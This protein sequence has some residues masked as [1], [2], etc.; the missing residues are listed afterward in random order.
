[1]KNK[2]STFDLIHTDDGCTSFHSKIYNENGHSSAGARTETVTHYIQGCDLYDRCSHSIS[3][4]EVGFGIGVGFQTTVEEL[5]TDKHINF[6]SVE[7]DE[8]LIKFAKT[9]DFFKEL[10]S[11]IKDGQKIYSLCKGDI[12]LFIF[13]GDARTS[14]KYIRNH[15]KFNAI[16]QDA[17]SP[18]RNPILWTYQW[19]NELKEMSEKDCIMST[20]SSSSSIRKA[21][22]KAGWAVKKG[23]KFGNK[24]SSTRA[25]LEGLTDQDILEQL[26]RSPAITLSDENAS[27]YKLDEK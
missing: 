13:V 11:E 21:M 14:V 8:S 1:M 4:F 24:R 20:Y 3:I 16:F 9:K 25:Y 17:F 18:K 23:V 5:G 7:I 6:V 26:E 12:N 19:F 2:E 15:F 10:K 22:I 27:E